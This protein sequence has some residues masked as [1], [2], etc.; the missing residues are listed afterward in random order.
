[1]PA[2]KTSLEAYGIA[3]TERTQGLSTRGR[4][5]PHRFIRRILK[6]IV[7]IMTVCSLWN[8]VVAFRG[9]RDMPLGRWPAHGTG[10][11][12]LFFSRCSGKSSNER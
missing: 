7:L 2:R 9:R 12:G 11:P 6:S 1:M 4:V 3:T 5:V 8:E 10:R